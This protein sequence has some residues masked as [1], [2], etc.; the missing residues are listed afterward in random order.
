DGPDA[1]ASSALPWACWAPLYGEACLVGRRV[2]GRA[3][4]GGRRGAGLAR[5]RQGRSGLGARGDSGVQCAGARVSGKA[6][7]LTRRTPLHYGSRWHALVPGS[8]AVVCS[9]RLG[10]GGT[11]QSSRRK[12]GPMRRSLSFTLIALSLVALVG[13][14][15]PSALAQ[16]G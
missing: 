3:R 10:L 8:A 16:S 4:L 11:H 13:G 12:D 15:S 1:R 6:P 14:T 7:R 2:A 5:P 9:P